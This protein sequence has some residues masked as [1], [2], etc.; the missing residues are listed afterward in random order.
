MKRYPCEMCKKRGFRSRN[1]LS[2]HIR[3]CKKKGA[4]TKRYSCSICKEPFMNRFALTR[5]LRS[6]KKGGRRLPGKE[7]K[8]KC[9]ECGEM[10]KGKGIGSHR[11]GKHGVSGT[12]RN[13]VKEQR[14]RN[15]NAFQS[16]GESNKIE[17]V[18]NGV[19]DKIREK[20]AEHR[21]KSIEHVTLAQRLEKMIEDLKVLL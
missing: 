13:A 19:I 15:G 10:F 17:Q 4:K 7:G 2:A 9:L 18:G 3:F 14:R 6:C 11:L 8:V 21:A 16:V 1:A 12:S 20:A 5:H